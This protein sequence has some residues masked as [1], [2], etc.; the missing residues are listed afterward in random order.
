MSLDSAVLEPI[1]DNPSMPELLQELHTC[2]KNEQLHRA[3]FYEK[4]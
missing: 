4:I 2:W 3:A 1:L